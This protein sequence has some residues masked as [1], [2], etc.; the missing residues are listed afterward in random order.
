MIKNNSKPENYYKQTNNLRSPYVSCFN[1]SMINGSQTVGI[2]LPD[3]KSLPAEEA[4]YDQP[5]D[6]LD[7][8]V[9][10]DKVIEYFKNNR[11]V[12]SLLNQDYDY[13]EIYAVEE[14]AFNDWIGK[15]VCKFIPHL[16][17]ENMIEIIDRGGAIVTSGKFCGFGHLVC[18]VGYKVDDV[19]HRLTH[20]I[21]DDPYGNPLKN[22][23]PL[24]QGGND[25]E[26][27]VEEF[28]LATNKSGA[29]TNPQHLGI[30]FLPNGELYNV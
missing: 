7:V 30:V 24:G 23:K 8:H 15:R 11:D 20:M 2:Q 13:R 28:W 26:Y 16:T 27:P 3:R 18:V 19:T 29:I 10:S 14:Y 4:T 21:I 1:T 6:Q 22:Y 5:E 9:H 17:M 25:V 12:Q